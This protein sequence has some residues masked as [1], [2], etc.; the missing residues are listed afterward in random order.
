MLFYLSKIEIIYFL[1]LAKRI[2][3]E[4][5]K[6]ILKEFIKN[7]T[8]EEI[9]KN[10]NFTKVTISRHLKKIL[11]EKKFF[12]ISTTT[13]Q[14]LENSKNINSK[15]PQLSSKEK[16]ESFNQ[17]PSPENS[18][19]EIP[20]LEYQ[21]DNI[22]QKDL[23]SVSITEVDLPKLVYMVVDNKIELETKPLKNYTEWG[24]LSEK[25]LNRKTIEIFFDLKVAKR[26]CL[27]DQ[28][29]I[30]VPNSNIFKIVAPILVSRG[31]TRIVSSEL[32]IAL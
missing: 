3:E 27:K 24:F 5:K 7:K 29:V 19:F 31:I 14:I 20:P 16:N 23:S 2:T 13:K 9:S 30:K 1:I 4:Q 21:I 22:P 12:E 6:E 11:G 25:D 17:E 18:F 8:I 28:K 32:L 10:F 15:E 26:S